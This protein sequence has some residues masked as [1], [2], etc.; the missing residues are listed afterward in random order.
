[1]HTES[2]VFVDV[3]SM[4]SCFSFLVDVESSSGCSAINPI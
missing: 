3:F 2:I 1:M 4:V